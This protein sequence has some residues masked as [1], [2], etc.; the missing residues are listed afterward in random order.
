MSGSST[1][2][3]TTSWKRNKQEARS[4]RRFLLLLLN[5]I[6]CFLIL[7]QIWKKKGITSF[8][9]LV[10]DSSNRTT[11]NVRNTTEQNSYTNIK[12]MKQ[13]NNKENNVDFELADSTSSIKQPIEFK[14]AHF[15][16][17][18]PTRN[19]E[20]NKD[21]CD[22]ILTYKDPDNTGRDMPGSTWTTARNVMY[23]LAMKK[24]RQ[25][26][27]AR[28]NNNDKNNNNNNNNLNI[29][30]HFCFMDGDVPINVNKQ[31]VIDRLMNETETQKIIVFNY[32]RVY[33]KNAL[34]MSSADANLNCFSSD[35]I[36]QY[37]PYS[38]MKDHQAWYL[39]QTDLIL[40][41]NIMEP[42]PFKIYTDIIIRNPAHNNEYPRNGT[43]GIQD[44][45]E[46]LLSDGYS[47]GCLM[48]PANPKQKTHTCEFRGKHL[49]TISL[50]ET[51]IRGGY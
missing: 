34:Y 6:L 42:F 13:N 48:P 20:C 5:L 30:S 41:A 14:P 1:N 25:H 22:T 36:H 7:R 15:Y 50:N 49:F 47:L 24:I 32:R 44:L 4:N 43:Q 33:P 8:T 51:H 18:C 39:S 10:F 3:R 21:Y 26:N 28:L 38:T 17:L 12:T 45:R 9:G 23:H 27:D 16:C 31:I 46:D 11:A 29:E 35:S 2:R 37:L 40:R 19:K